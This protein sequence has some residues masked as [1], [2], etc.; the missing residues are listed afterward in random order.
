MWQD[1][2]NALEHYT[3]SLRH[4][5]SKATVWANRSAT[6]LALGNAGEALRDAQIARTIDKTYAKVQAIPC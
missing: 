1:F 2:P 3:N 4:D 6:L 5:T